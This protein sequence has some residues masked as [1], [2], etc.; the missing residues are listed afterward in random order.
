MGVLLIIIFCVF[1]LCNAKKW[2]LE[3]LITAAF[4]AVIGQILPAWVF[5]FIGATGY[6]NRSDR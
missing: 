1:A 2:W 6:A 3:I 5:L 4:L